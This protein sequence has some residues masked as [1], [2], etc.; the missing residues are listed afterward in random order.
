M[1]KIRWCAACTKKGWTQ[2]TY[3][4]RRCSHCGGYFCPAHLKD[5]ERVRVPMPPA[6]EKR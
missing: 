2:L 3:N 1:V 5:H 4:H 6:K